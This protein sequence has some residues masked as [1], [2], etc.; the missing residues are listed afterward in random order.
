MTP[1]TRKQVIIDMLN[2]GALNVGIAPITTEHID[3]VEK[4]LLKREILS[5]DESQPLGSNGR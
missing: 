2:H 3:R 1:D 4:I 5:K